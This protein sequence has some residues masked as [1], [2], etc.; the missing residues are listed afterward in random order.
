MTLRA[1]AFALLW[2]LASFT[3]PGLALAQPPPAPEIEQ[4]DSPFPDGFEPSRHGDTFR[5]GS[6]YTLPASDEAGDVVVVSANADIDGH[7]HGD[8]VVILGSARIAGTARIDGDFVVIGG[9][10]TV[11]PGAIV[12]RDLVVIGG[13]LEAPPDFRPGGEPVVIGT[14]T[15]G[16]R[17]EAFLPWVTRGL[18]W[19]RLIVPE[20]AWMWWVIGFFF[21][22]YLAINLLA[23]RPARA[24]A[25]V[26][27]D[28]PLTTFL[29]GLLVLLLGGPVIFILIATVI[30]IAV[31]PFAICGLI[32]VGLVGKVGVARWIGRT[33]VPEK[34]EGD[35]RA[36]G[37]RSFVIGF[38]VLCIAYMIPVLGFIA[39][40][41]AGVIALGAGVLAFIAYYQRE[42]PA[43]PARTAAA[44]AAPGVPTIPVDAP[45]PPESPFSHA[46]PV[47]E[48][49]GP[50]LPPPD[51]AGFPFASFRDRLAAIALDVIL[52]G[53]TSAFLELGREGHGRVFVLLLIYHV[54]FWTW[55]GTTVGGIICQ[56]RVVKTNGQ[57]LS[58]ADA[59]VRGLSSIFSIAVLAIGVLWILKDPERQ[60]WHD[61]IAGTY[62]VKVPR[63]YPL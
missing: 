11:E 60:S 7:V 16:A 43:A 30:G 29:V 19:G 36:Q 2:S 15:I 17:V 58:F 12:S 59:L 26:L 33:I 5:M 18:L 6:H 32:L 52:I 4:P 40:A 21:F 42:N 8:L 49:P 35:S 31:V 45:P 61:K 53:I 38:A 63:N 57:R 14:E 50:T 46:A 55:K 1:P 3:A 41:S 9:S 56:L 34:P 48:P 13:A 24:C 51:L 28:K 25:D 39:W 62:V 10:A 54:A 23:D 47:M 20:L 44:A 27:T 37:T 22:L